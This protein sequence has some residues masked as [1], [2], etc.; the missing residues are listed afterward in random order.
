[1]HIWRLWWIP[2]VS[3]VT[4][5]LSDHVGYLLDHWNRFMQR[6]RH[7]A[8]IFWIN[9][10]LYP[11]EPFLTGSMNQNHLS[12]LRGAFYITFHSRTHLGPLRSLFSVWNAYNVVFSAHFAVV[13]KH[14]IESW[15][16]PI[17]QARTIYD[18]AVITK[19]RRISICA[20]RK[21]ILRL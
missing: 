13:L 1:M 17:G 4:L 6:H 21:C 2:R 5:W 20:R 16:F 19:S 11:C 3:I 8:E 12:G 7:S 14:A 15:S 18:W 9:P 10:F